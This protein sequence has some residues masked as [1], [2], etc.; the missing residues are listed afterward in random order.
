[1]RK[2]KR[3]VRITSMLGEEDE[4][5]GEEE[6]NDEEKGEAEFDV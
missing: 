1:M 3:K 5:K 4:G 2:T 6:E